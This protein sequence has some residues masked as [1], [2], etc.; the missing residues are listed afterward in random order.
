MSARSVILR[1]ALGPESLFAARYAYNA[2]GDV[3][4]IGLAEPGTTDDQPKWIIKKIVYDGQ[5]RQVASLFAGGRIKF[6]Q[7]WNSRESAT[8]Q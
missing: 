7:V 4:Y 5:R 1:D 3:E 8:Y 6:D 2:S